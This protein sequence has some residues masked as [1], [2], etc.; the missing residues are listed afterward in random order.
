MIK[1]DG[2]HDE[3]IWTMFAVAASFCISFRG[4]TS[5]PAIANK[6]AEIADALVLKFRERCVERA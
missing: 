4:E 1:F 3:Q 5:A 2:Y 6:S